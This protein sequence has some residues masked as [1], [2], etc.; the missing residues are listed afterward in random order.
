MSD[1]TE[2]FAGALL[3]VVYA[4]DSD[5]IGDNYQDQCDEPLAV[6]KLEAMIAY[7]FAHKQM[8]AQARAMG[9]LGCLDVDT[10]FALTENLGD[11]GEMAPPGQPTGNLV[12][13]T[14]QSTPQVISV[15]TDI[16]TDR[17]DFVNALEGEQMF[18]GWSVAEQLRLIDPP[19]PEDNDD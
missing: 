7:R 16:M 5:T 13:E 6:D 9:A 12:V 11:D 19:N 1:P 18:D 4:I 14:A 3:T 15:T 17:R 10:L 8:V 2:P